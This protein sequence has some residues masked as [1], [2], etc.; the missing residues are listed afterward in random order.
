M[1]DPS[2]SATCPPFARAVL[3]LSLLLSWQ[4]QAA[5]T[6]GVVAAGSASIAATGAQTTITQGSASAVINWQGFSVGAGE[7]VRFVQPGS[8]SVTLNRVLGGDASAIHGRLS[9]NGK[10]FLVNPAG[11]LFGPGASVN[12]GGLVASTLN[13][14][15]ADFMAGRHSFSGGSRAAVINQGSITAAD[16][17]YVALL[18]AHVANEGSIS[19]RLGSVALAAGEAIRLDVLG[20]NLLH[21]TVERAAVD[22]LARNGGVIQADGGQVLLTTQAAGSLLSGAVN[23]T[24]VIQAQTLDVRSGTIRLMGGMAAGTVDVAGTLDASAPNGGQGGFIETSAAR[25]R[26]H[27]GAKVTTAAALG[28]TGEWL[29][30]PEDFTIG[31]AAGDNI[32]GPTLSAL[33]VTNS[34]I[35]TTAAGPNDTTAGAPPV[36]RLNSG[37]VGNGDIFVNEAVSWT[38]APSTTTLTLNASRDV[39]INRAITAVNGNLV[40]CCG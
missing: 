25:V 2:A 14:S 17:G 12:V 31:S 32:S 23:N 30:D 4:V 13:I 26:V 33:L 15:D 5:P 1:H 21:V 7:A 35:I 37:P 39:V 27:D 24:G 6:G 34:V 8:S 29:I 20:D 40:V 28:K 22:A 10:V 16:G 18:G 9:A 19:A 36:T 3:A 11:V 38:A